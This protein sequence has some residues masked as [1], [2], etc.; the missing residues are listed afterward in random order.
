[1]GFGFWVLGWWGFA[2][3]PNTQYPTPHVVKLIS[4][5]FHPLIK[6]IQQYLPSITG[7]I[8]IFDLESKAPCET[9]RCMVTLF[10]KQFEIRN[11]KP[12]SHLSFTDFSLLL[13]E[14]Q[15]CYTRKRRP[16]Y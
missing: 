8:L 7:L 5:N 12:A 13:Y 9:R 2:P 11:I 4:L 15:M 1:M 3:P 16:L 6:L 10:E 14:N